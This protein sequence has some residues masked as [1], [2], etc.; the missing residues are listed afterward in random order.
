MPGTP[1]IAA[2]VVMWDWEATRRLA[3]QVEDGLLNEPG[4]EAGI[5][6]A[7]APF[8][9]QTWGL[10]GRSRV[11]LI[12][13]HPNMI[14]QAT[15]VGFLRET[16]T[17]DLDQVDV[18]REGRDRAVMEIRFGGYQ[19]QSELAYQKLTTDAEMASQVTVA[20]G[21]DPCDRR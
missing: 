5:E 8:T 13:G 18:R 17:F 12:R 19:R 14:R 11:L 4:F 21:V 7:S 15:I 3:M 10:E 2:G 9:M 6:F 1:S 20:F 16:L